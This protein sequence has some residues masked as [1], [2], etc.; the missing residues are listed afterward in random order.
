MR[1][2]TIE[3]SEFQKA[4]LAA[5]LAMY[6]E[7]PDVPRTFD[8]GENQPQILIGDL[9]ELVADAHL[10]GTDDA[11]PLPVPFKPVCNVM[12]S[13]GTCARPRP[14]PVHHTE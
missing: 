3:V 10:E 11:G 13:I 4:A 5:V 12:D 14:C 7:T 9:M 2:Y 6:I 1:R 8:A